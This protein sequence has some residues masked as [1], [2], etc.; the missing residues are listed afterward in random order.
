MFSVETHPNASTTMDVFMCHSLACDFLHLSCK[1]GNAPALGRACCHCHGLLTLLMKPLNFRK[2]EAEEKSQTSA[3]W[4]EMNIFWDASNCLR[5]QTLWLLPLPWLQCYSLSTRNRMKRKHSKEWTREEQPHQKLLTRWHVFNVLRG[6]MNPYS[7]HLQ[8]TDP[9]WVCIPWA[10]CSAK[11][12]DKIGVLQTLL[13]FFDHTNCSFQTLTWISTDMFWK[14]NLRV[15]WTPWW[16]NLD[17]FC[18]IVLSVFAG[19]THLD[20]SWLIDMKYLNKYNIQ[21][22]YLNLNAIRT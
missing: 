18:Y 22:Y 6:L 5:F 3:V 10:R 15:P 4:T 21:D 13:T 1:M 11:P 8:T 16:K 9:G 7:S 2:V 17:L 20:R 14:N 12:A 19:S